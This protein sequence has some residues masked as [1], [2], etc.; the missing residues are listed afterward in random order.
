MESFK[1]VIDGKECEAFPGETVLEVAERNGI[2]IP[3][4]CYHKEL[5]PEGACRVCLVEVEGAPRLATACT[6]KAMPD[7]V[8]KTNTERVKRARAGVIELILNN[9]TLECPICDKSG[10]CELQMTGFRFGPK[11]SRYREPRREKDVVIQGPLIEIDNDRCILCRRCV[12]MCGENMGNRVLGILKR[13][14]KAYISPFNGDFIE[15]GCEHCGS[16]VDVC[17]V[18]SLLDRAFKYKDRPWRMEKTWTTCTLCG[19]GCR[20]EVDTY[21]GRIKRVVGRIGVNS[22]HNRGYLCVRGKW[23]WDSV[24][25][26]RRLSEPLVKEGEE[27]K[28]VSLEEALKRLGEIVRGRKVNLFVGSSLTNEE[29][30]ALKGRFGD[31]AA[32]D[33]YGYGALLRGVA[34]VRGSLE[35]DPFTSLYDADVIFVVGDFIN[36]L[37]PVVATLLRLA[38]IQ[39]GKRL[40]RVGTFDEPK[41]DSVAFKSLKVDQ[42]ELIDTLK[43]L[44]V[45]TFDTSFTSG[46]REVDTLAKSLRGKKLGFLISPFLAFSPEGYEVAKTVAFLA[47]RLGAPVVAVP[48]KVNAKSVV[49]LFKLK[50]PSELNGSVNLLVDVDFLRDFP[51]EELPKADYTVI[52]TPYYTHELPQADLV[53]PIEVGLEKSGTVEGVQGSLKLEPAVTSDYSL[54]DIVNSLPATTVESVEPQR[55]ELSKEPGISRLSKPK[56]LYLTVVSTRTGW[57]SVSYYS[58]NVASVAEGDRLLLNPKD[59]PEGSSLVTVKTEGGRL[60][61]PFET[62][63]AVPEGHVLLLVENVTRDISNLIRGAFPATSGIPCELEA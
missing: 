23:G 38:V 41:L 43:H 25:S 32:S 59:A 33:A 44:I 36:R 39:R 5:R 3:V 17:P 50:K 40:V 56:G 8:V 54:V 58:S 7:M 22:G 6:L 45:G 14:Y 13:G 55:V 18:G 28:R 29:L 60:T 27:L 4:F 21:H 51:G 24:Y 47:D 30:Q 1:I 9:H 31:V 26:D 12:R 19:T 52:L 57:N 16:C 20:L 10:E 42:W 53:I 48:P 35:T 11:K 46:N 37:T 49:K 63:E 34:S 61:L 62:S 15:S 2:L